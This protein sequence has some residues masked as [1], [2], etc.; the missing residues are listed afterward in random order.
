MSLQPEPAQHPV[1]RSKTPWSLRVESY[2]LFLK[3][4]E[5]PK[6]VY[7]PLEEALASEECGK[8]EGGLGA[9]MII[10]YVDTPV[11]RFCYPF[12]PCET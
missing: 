12:Y 4:K 6:G 9:V 10:R 3:L 5:L 7:D 1:Q 11:G 2:V 8:F